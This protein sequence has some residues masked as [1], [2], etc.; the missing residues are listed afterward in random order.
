MSKQN[1]V[2]T[3]MPLA[4]FLMVLIGSNDLSGS[5]KNGEYIKELIAPFYGN[6]S[7][8]YMSDELYSNN[9]SYSGKI[10]YREDLTLYEP[11]VAHLHNYNFLGLL[12]LFSHF[13]SIDDIR[14]VTNTETVKQCYAIMLK[15][16]TQ[17]ANTKFDSE[18]CWKIAQMFLKEFVSV[19]S[20]DTVEQSYIF[21]KEMIR[22]ASGTL[23]L[24]GTTLKDALSISRDHA[25][26]SIINDIFSNTNIAVVNIYLMNYL[27]VGVN[28]E[29]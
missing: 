1:V 2:T 28:R 29:D 3:N 8:N 19:E 24:A 12:K 21:R 11:I 27:Y 5:G 10:T 18:Y 25:N 15:Y 9:G 22:K 20:L 14:T 13:W 7:K 26:A 17:T 6:E 23:Y 16:R 4:V